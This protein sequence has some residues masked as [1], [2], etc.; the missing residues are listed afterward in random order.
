MLRSERGYRTEYKEGIDSE[1]NVHRGTHTWGY[2]GGRPPR[3][4]RSLS[5]NLREVATLCKDSE[6]IP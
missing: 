5:V 3:E 6:Q 1:F 2:C 4:D